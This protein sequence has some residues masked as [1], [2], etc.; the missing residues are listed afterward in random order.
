VLFDDLNARLD[1]AGE[2]EGFE[3]IPVEVL[4]RRV[5]ADMGLSGELRFT[6]SALVSPASPKA[7]GA[8]AR[9]PE[10]EDTG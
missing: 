1:E 6:A 2:V 8:G 9:G 3:D 7:D 10:P 5:A 4:A